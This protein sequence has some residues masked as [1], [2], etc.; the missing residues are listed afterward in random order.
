MGTR[1]SIEACP[2][3]ATVLHMKLNEAADNGGRVVNVI[4][5]PEREVVTSREF[6]DDF[7]VMV[8]SGYI[9]ILEYFEQDMKNER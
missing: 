4:W 5:Q 1:Y 9:I 2:D 7:K 6:A 8:E 3:D